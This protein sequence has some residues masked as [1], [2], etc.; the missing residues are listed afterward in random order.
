[1][2]ARNARSGCA[3]PPSAASRRV[4]VRALEVGHLGVVVGEQRRVHV[5]VIDLGRARL[6]IL[7]QR[8]HLRAHA[9]DRRFRLRAIVARAR[10]GQPLDHRAVLRD[11]VLVERQLAL[12]LFPVHVPAPLGLGLAPRVRILGQA[13]RARR[14]R[15]AAPDPTPPAR[16]PPSRGRA[17]DARRQPPASATLRTTSAA[18]RI[19]A[20]PTGPPRPPR[21]RSRCRRCRAACPARPPAR[22][23]PARR[24]PCSRRGSRCC[25]CRVRR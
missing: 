25:R 2:R 11:P 3:S 22:P 18:T 4:G 16:A 21:A 1:M 9:L 6:Q 23:A 8:R 13:A 20:R 19:A 12:A 24:C 10:R 7:P 15:R 5:P 17:S 14:R